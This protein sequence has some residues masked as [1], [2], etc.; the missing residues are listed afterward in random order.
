MADSYVSKLAKLGGTNLPK[1]KLTVIS[2]ESM[3]RIHSLNLSPAKEEEL[4]QWIADLEV[5]GKGTVE[6]WLDELEQVD[7]TPV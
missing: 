7:T 5:S 3:G 6:E 1:G 4:V 2:E